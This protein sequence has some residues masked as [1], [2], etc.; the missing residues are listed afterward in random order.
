MSTSRITAYLGLD[1]SR[2]QSGLEK[3]NGLLGRFKSFATVAG[4]GG[5]GKFLS[6]LAA[7]K[8]FS[9]VIERA[10]EARNAARELNRTVD[11]GTE[12]V[13]RYADAWDDLKERAQ[14]R[15]GDI[16][17]GILSLF[18][19]FGEKLGEK[20]EMSRSGRSAEEI[21]RTGRISQEAAAN[22]DRLG[23]PEALLA[24][25]RR[26]EEK[27]S[28]A[29]KADEQSMAEVARL[30]NEASDRREQTAFNA[31]SPAQQLTTLELRRLQF[32]KE[33]ANTSRS[34][35]VRARALNDLSKT[36]E[37]IAKTKAEMER[38]ITAEK[39][40]QSDEQMRTNEGAAAALEKYERSLA[41][42]SA[43]GSSLAT[44]RKDA[45]GF[46]VGD[47]ARGTRGNI[48]A[49]EA[50]RRIERDESTARTLSDSGRQVSIFD[51]KAQR[52]REVGA[53][54][55]QQRALDARTM[56]PG[57]T[58]GE[59]NPFAAAEQELKAAG[60]ELKAAAEALKTAVISVEV[61]DEEN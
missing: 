60:S 41:R 25:K 46:T 37:E 32:Q 33:Y 16:G 50:A 34:A 57:L 2:F 42:D 5:A 27:R 7:V 14:S 36:E 23:S 35:I 4:M 59:K 3:V 54:F 11:K 56:L 8:G 43:A 48:F 61:E 30:M 26:G 47:A 12:S 39:K 49:R 10:Q 1:I 20:F 45:L 21:S 44:A 17:I 18:T 31:L 58:S 55:F 28:A 13:A 6:V 38:E 51:S 15:A 22:A 53:E 9:A 24:A 19:Q 29:A 52:N 40:R